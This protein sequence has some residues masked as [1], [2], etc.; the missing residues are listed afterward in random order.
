[1]ADN[2]PSVSQA[3]R[4]AEMHWYEDG[5]S[6]IFAGLSFLLVV[7]TLQLAPSPRH[8]L[9]VTILFFAVCSL[10]IAV[11][12]LQTRI[13]EWLKRKLGYP[14]IGFVTPPPSAVEV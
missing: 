6:S 7:A 5:I 8:H 11:S 14:R 2:L 9:A 12:I 1:M 3:V 4:T 10:F 13:V